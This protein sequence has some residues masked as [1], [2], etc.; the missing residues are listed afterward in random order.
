[1][2][3]L[4][5][6]GQNIVQELSA[7]HGFSADAV[8]HMLFAVLNG[9]GSMAQFQHPEFAGS[10]QWMRGGMIMLGDMFNG[11]LKGRV[12]SLCSELANVLANQPGLLQGGSFQSQSQGG[13]SQQH[14]A[15]GSWGPSSLFV[16]DP[17]D[18]WWPSALGAPSATGAQNNVRY[19]YFAQQRRLAVKTGGQV[20]VYDT[21]DHQIGGFAQQQGMGGSITFSSQYGTVDLSRLP[22]ALRNGQPVSQPS[23]PSAPQHPASSAAPAVSSPQVASSSST[24]AP[25]AISPSEVISALEK[26]GELEAKGILTKEEFATKKAQ[27]L[28]RL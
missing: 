5:A 18:N 19:A 8:A 22:V 13:S 28:S 20:W 27:L 17:E 2:R 9:N 24:A 1:M 14:Q 7:R 23:A 26:L 25:H 21:L 3:Q 12:D 6:E 4:T 10:G 15:T 11:Y 16:P